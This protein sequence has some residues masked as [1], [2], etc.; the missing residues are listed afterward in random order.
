MISPFSTVSCYMSTCRYSGRRLAFLFALLIAPLCASA[1]AAIIEFPLDCPRQFECGQSWSCD[2][3]LGVSFSRIDK[4]YIEWSGGITAELVNTD[5][6]LQPTAPADAR[7][8]AVLSGRFELAPELFYT[9]ELACLFFDA[10]GQTYP[11]P[12]RFKVISQFDEINYAP[13]EFVARFAPDAYGIIP[14][15]DRQNEILAS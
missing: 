15:V 2:F 7:F 12:D 14:S 1:G 6:P 9:E 5:D 10:G 3:D 4:V 13:N 8:F 11:A